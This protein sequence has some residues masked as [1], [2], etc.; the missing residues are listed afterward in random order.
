MSLKRLF[1]IVL[2]CVSLAFPLIADSGSDNMATFSKSDAFAQG[3]GAEPADSIEV[4]ELREVVVTDKPIRYTAAGYVASLDQEKVNGRTLSQVLSQMPFVDADESSIMVQSR[5]VSAYYIDGIKASGFDEVKMMPTESIKSVQADYS[6]GAGE[7]GA[8]G[9]V[10]RITLRRVEERGYYGHVWATA[11]ALA[12][13]GYRGEP[14]GTY[15]T[16]QQGPVRITAM[17]QNVHHKMMGRNENSYSFD[18]GEAFSARER[19]D[20]WQKKPYGN[21]VV[22][23]QIN[24]RH[25]LGLSISALKMGIRD[26]Q[27]S[28]NIVGES[29]DK[30]RG[31]KDS[32]QYNGVLSWDGKFSQSLSL[33][34][35]MSYIANR[36][37]NKDAYA[38]F[39]GG[40]RDEA[41]AY[42]RGKTDLLKWQASATWKSGASTWNFG[43]FLQRIEARDYDTRAFYGAVPDLKMEGWRQ[44]A[45]ASYDAMAG[46]LAIS[47]G[48]RLQTSRKTVWQAEEKT[49]KSKAELSPRL[50]LTYFLDQEK[51]NMLVLSYEHSLEEMPYSVMSL[52]PTFLT[53][54]S[55]SIGNPNLA[56]PTSDEAG[57]TARFLGIFNVYAIYSST[58]HPICY[59]SSQAPDNAGLVRSMAKNG[60]YEWMSFSGVEVS[61]PV[62]NVFKPKLSIAYKFMGAR[63]ED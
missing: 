34:A 8:A 15:S 32:H 46:K 39:D 26:N 7:D 43:V 47:A 13:Y 23:W 40:V 56:T 3:S 55:Y 58:S 29:F 1:A 6:G 38:S 14:P 49:F 59:A 45:F 42:S 60:K 27:T 35:K 9:P 11:G 63:N 44:E 51:G 5:A 37:R 16:T 25:S 21:A 4:K 17:A 24:G 54:K 2:A 33:S 41:D 28:K 22:L 52:Y 62:G 48:L 53:P 12:A 30:V 61:L 20:G 19:Y 18:S 31:D 57:L 50:S 10:I 36:S